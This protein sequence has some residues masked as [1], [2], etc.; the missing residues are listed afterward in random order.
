MT[1]ASLPERALSYP[2]AM[3][4]EYGY[5]FL[6]TNGKEVEDRLGERASVVVVVG[7]YRDR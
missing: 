6:E 1:M 7:G 4:T 3:V 2:D 5:L